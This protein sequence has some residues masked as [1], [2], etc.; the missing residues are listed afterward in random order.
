MIV[1]D[2]SL[3][4]AETPLGTRWELLTDGVMGGVSQGRLA[5]EVIDGRPCL[6]LT[7]EV[8][9]ENNGGFVQMA[10]DLRPDGGA[11]D[12]SGFAGVALTA[13]GNDQGYALHLRTADLTRPWQ[14]YRHGFVS[15]SA[16]T[17]HRLPF[18]SLVAHRT[19]APFDAGRVRRIGLVAIGRA[20]R[21][22]LALADLRFYA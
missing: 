2:R 16:W 6:R 17:A 10:L 21:A 13:R 5:P 18:D 4:G 8:R 14:S 7:G 3:P 19:D 9:L 1:D 22:D 20:F 11:V 12:L 15:S